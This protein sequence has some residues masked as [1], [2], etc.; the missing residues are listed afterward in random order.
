MRGRRVWPYAI[1]LIIATAFG[2]AVNRLGK[3]AEE[4]SAKV[5]CPADTAP[6]AA[7][8]A[9]KAPPKPSADLDR[10]QP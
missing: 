6:N 3:P 4:T 7:A 2:V 10:P 1:I 8:T 5:T 9:V